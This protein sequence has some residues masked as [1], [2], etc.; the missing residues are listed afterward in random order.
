[1][2]SLSFAFFRLLHFSALSMTTSARIISLEHKVEGV[3]QGLAEL[4][5]SIVSR[6][7]CSLTQ[8]EETMLFNG[9]PRLMDPLCYL[10]HH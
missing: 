5:A 10:R 1:M 3:R 9:L 4:L 8:P 7:H 6:D 2:V